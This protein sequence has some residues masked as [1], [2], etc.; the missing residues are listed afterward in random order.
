MDYF[1]PCIVFYNSN[2]TQNENIIE[3]LNEALLKINCG[4]VPIIDIDI[5][6]PSSKKEELIEYN[7]DSSNSLV[8]VIQKGTIINKFYDL[9][10]YIKG[11]KEVMGI[12]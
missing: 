11:L 1:R 4:D 10:S 2:D 3:K 9:N 5:S 8:F 12:K 6:K 7:V